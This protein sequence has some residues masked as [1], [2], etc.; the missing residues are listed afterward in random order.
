MAGWRAYLAQDLRGNDADQEH[1]DRH[2]D[3]EDE[4]PKLAD[5]D[6]AHNG[7]AAEPADA[8]LQKQ[9]NKT[10]EH[11][12]APRECAG[13]NPDAGIWQTYHALTQAET[14]RRLQLTCG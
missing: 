10:S 1:D 4:Q 12:V 5:V 2:H 7:P 9:Q 13:G 3:G 11:G 14:D 6:V 8:D